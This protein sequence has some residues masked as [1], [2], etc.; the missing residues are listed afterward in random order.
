MECNWYAAD[1]P[2]RSHGPGQPDAGVTLDLKHLFSEL[3]RLEIELWN[4]VEARVRSEHG[5]PLGWYAVMQVVARRAACR[6]HDIAGDLSITVGG[7]SKLVDRI[8]AAGYC[9]RRANPG[10]RRSSLIVLT[11]GQ[12][13]LA[14]L[15]ATVERELAV[16]LGTALPGRSLAQLT[17][18]LT[19]LRS[20]AR[21]AGIPAET[22]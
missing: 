14:Q 20:A 11:P 6:V 2:P 17:K 10:D 7:T 15:T 22:A 4:A 5:H 16:R 1:M 19:R 21:S 18:T 13:M 8:E 3:V 9:T 12:R